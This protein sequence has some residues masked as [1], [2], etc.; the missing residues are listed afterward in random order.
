MGLRSQ[1]QKGEAWDGLYYEFFK[2]SPDR[3]DAQL[4]KIASEL[5]LHY[6]EL[7]RLLEKKNF[8]AIKNELELFR[9][10]ERQIFLGPYGYSSK[11]TK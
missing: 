4:E 11:A 10:R 1:E 6:I 7:V 2:E 3:I 5:K 8:I 9:E